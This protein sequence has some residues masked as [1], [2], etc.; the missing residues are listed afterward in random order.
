[1]DQVRS[2]RFQIT[3]YSESD[4][5]ASL[6][7]CYKAEVE[8]RGIS[9][10]EDLATQRRVEQAAK[11]LCRDLK[12]GFM[13]YGSVGSGKTT[14]AKAMCQLIRMLYDRFELGDRRVPVTMTTALELSKAATDDDT[15]RFNSLKNAR[16]LF[17]DDVGVEPP[18][19]KNWGNEISPVVELIYFRYDF[20][21]PMI[22][23]SNLSFREL[24]Q[25]YGERV[26][27]RMLEMFNGIEFKQ[28]MSYRK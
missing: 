23:T 20:Q 9:Y 6:L 3:E 22:I 19:V 21:K 11:W 26:G 5:V 2:Q 27:D 15:S 1:M 12:P 18:T 28:T 10:T 8:K 16:F 25:R 24:K 14:L 13:L 17:L 7:L 4:I